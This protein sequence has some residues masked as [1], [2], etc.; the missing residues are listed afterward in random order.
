MPH[1]NNEDLEEERRVAYVGVTRAK[2]LIG[3]TFANMR[4]GQ[5]S[6]PSQFLYELAG[7]KGAIAS[8][9]ARRPTAPTNVCRCCPIASGSD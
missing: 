8:G 7:R 4:F 2:R 9:P 6:R 1:V 3:L 5:T